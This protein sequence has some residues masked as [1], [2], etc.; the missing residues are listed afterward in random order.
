MLECGVLHGSVPTAWEHLKGDEMS[1]RSGLPLLF[2]TVL[3][4][5]SPLAL[6]QDPQPGDMTIVLEDDARSSQL[7]LLQ[8][9]QADL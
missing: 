4:C 8:S 2:A 7:L 3:L 1:I 9:I 5:T 6:A